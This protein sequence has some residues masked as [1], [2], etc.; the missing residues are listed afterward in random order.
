[1]RFALG[2]TLAVAVAGCHWPREKEKSQAFKLRWG[3]LNF[4]FVF[5]IDTAKLK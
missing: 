1:M 4:P 5:A 3:E 2:F